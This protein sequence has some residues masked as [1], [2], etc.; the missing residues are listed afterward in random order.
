MSESIIRQAEARDISGMLE[1]A[2]Q[3]REEYARYQSVF[4]KPAADALE[5][6]RPWFAK[7]IEREDVVT[8]VYEHD[9]IVQ[10]FV[11]AS[12]VPAPPVYDVP[13]LTCNI[14]DFC[15]QEH[16]EWLRSGRQLLD[17]AMEEA[18][19]R[20]AAQVVVVCAH[21]DHPKRS[22]LSDAGLTIASEWYTIPL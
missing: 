16:E 19:K 5:R 14:D 18:R 3:R 9:A 10:G 17:A 4:W 20:G 21:L 12:F 13:G 7:L 8:L 2:A 15:V 1:L 11:I 22:M 6:Q